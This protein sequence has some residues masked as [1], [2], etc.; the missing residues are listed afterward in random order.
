MKQPTSYYP[1]GQQHPST[2]ALQAYLADQLSPTESQEITK[3][4]ADCDMCSDILDGLLDL[5]APE[6]IEQKNAVLYTNFRDKNLRKKRDK[7]PLSILGGLNN[8]NIILLVIALLLLLTILGS[9]FYLSTYKKDQNNNPTSSSTN[10]VDSMIASNPGIMQTD[11]IAGYTP[12]S[13]AID[14]NIARLMTDPNIDYE[15]YTQNPNPGPKYRSQY[16]EEIYVSPTPSPEDITIYGTG[17]NSDGATTPQSRYYGYDKTTVDNTPK[18][19]SSPTITIGHQ[20]IR[21]DDI[22][23]KAQ[24]YYRNGQ[25]QEGINFLE[26]YARAVK[27]S[28]PDIDYWLARL[29]A[30]NDQ[31]SYARFYLERLA[32]YNNPYTES[33]KKMLGQD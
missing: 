29:Y 4:L 1:P 26:K 31:L 15:Y 3:H 18:S 30:Q 24:R 13:A 25:Y 14:S 12:D 2:E 8:T 19:T 11:D 27:E 17:G 16:H 21:I 23:A 9:I 28:V 20:V 5:D 6:G 32:G 22:V 33:A 7:N 10:R